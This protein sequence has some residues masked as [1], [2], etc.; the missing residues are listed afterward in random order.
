MSLKRKIVFFV[1]E[2]VHVL[3]LTG[4]IQVF[5]EAN[6][7]GANYELLFFSL[8][9]NVKSS[10]GLIFSTLTH[11]SKINIEK[12][13]F[14]FLPG[15]EMDYLRS[16]NFKKEKKFFTWLMKKHK[17]GVNICTVCTGAFILAETGL[18]NLKPCTTHWKRI[19]ELKES[20]PL[21]Q[22]KNDVLYT[23]EDNLYTSAGITS[24]IDLSLAIVEEHYGPLFAHKISRE[25][26]VYY[27]RSGNHTQQNVYLNYR[28]HMQTGIHSVQD[29]LIANI[30]NKFTIAQLAS[31]A[32]MSER[33]LT[34]AFKKATGLTINQYKKQLRL[35]KLKTLLHNTE[36]KSDVVANK[37]GYKNSRQLRR[38]KNN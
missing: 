9:N 7:Y 11:F 3:D 10:A 17:A 8:V 37:V 2:M 29:W 18:L 13:D 30:E 4:S 25:L 6:S 27:R 35:E 21:L 22:I 34:R 20:Y 32:N 14:I 15:A 33:N 19:G 12:G 26:L 23:H 1:P 38:I 28:N 24:G 36:M 5:Y 16:E 31:I